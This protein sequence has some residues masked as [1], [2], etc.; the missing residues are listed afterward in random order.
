MKICRTVAELRRELNTF[1]AAAK[2]VGFVPTMGA[3]HKGHG[4]LMQRARTDHGCVV[5]SIFVNP[6]QFNEI[7][8]FAVYPV[9]LESDDHFCEQHNVDLLFRPVTSEIY[10]EGFDVRVSEEPVSQ[11][12]CGKF[13]PGHFEGMLTV[14]L[15]LLQIVQAESAYFG[16]KDF[17]QLVLVQKL[18][19][20]LFINTKIVPCPIVREANGLAMSSR[21]E[22]L[23]EGDR[24]KA[25]LIYSILSQAGS[26][27]E[28]R[29]NLRREGFEVEYVEDW[30]GRRLTAV[31]LGAVRLIDNV[32]IDQDYKG[33]THDSCA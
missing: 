27:P 2:S 15:K 25:G 22:R 16:E 21:N 6:T 12:L 9:G 31:K 18:V 26:A 13:R 14:V 33:V 7:K 19:N 5:V 29:D 8:D 30:L 1:R 24:Q 3:L 28:C 32:A 23:S 17:Q 10:P 20:N 11:R 4:S